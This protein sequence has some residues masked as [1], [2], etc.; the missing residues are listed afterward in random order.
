MTEVDWVKAVLSVITTG[1]GVLFGLLGT[2]YVTWRRE[3]R[4]YRAMLTAIASEAR[5]NKAVLNDSF[6]KYYD[7]GIV[8][9]EFSAATIER[10]VGDP[11]FA[12]HAK[13]AHLDII[14]EYLRNIRLANSYRE[15]AE[16]LQLGHDKKIAEQWLE[17]ILESWRDNLKQCKTSIDRVIALPANDSRRAAQP[18]APADAPQAARR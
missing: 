9:R 2:G 6:M 15:K 8:L 16:L 1:L 4:A 3:G 5:N 13:S 12:K 7:S 10:C 11:L 18:G 17:N 14:Y